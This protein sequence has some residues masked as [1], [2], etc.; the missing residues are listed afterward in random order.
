MQS[1]LK[2]LFLKNKLPNLHGV[3]TEFKLK[4]YPIQN[5]KKT[6][7]LDFRL[8]LLDCIT[9]AIWGPNVHVFKK[10]GPF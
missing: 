1:P 4:Y 9:F 3:I 7:M 2:M 6:N 5:A 10:K 8:I